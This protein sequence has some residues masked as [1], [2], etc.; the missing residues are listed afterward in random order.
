MDNLNQG[1]AGIN[2]SSSLY[3]AEIA[4]HL[5]VT[6]DE[7]KQRFASRMLTSS[8]PLCQH[9]ESFVINAVGDHIDT[10]RKLKKEVFL[11][12]R[13]SDTEKARLLQ[14]FS[15][16]YRLVFAH[17]PSDIG[18]HL[19]YRALNEI[20]TYRCYDLLSK[21][22]YNDP[23]Y[24]LLIKE[25]GASVPKLVKY[26]RNHVHACTPNLNIDDTIRITNTLSTLDYYQRNGDK[27]QRHLAKLYMRDPKYRCYNKSQYCFTRC[28][29]LIFAHSSYDCTLT[30]IAN[31]MDSSCAVKAIGFIHY[32][33]KIL[34]NLTKGNDNGLNWELT[35]RHKRFY[36]T[37]WFD[38]DYQNSYHHDLDTYL[39]IVKTSLCTS[40]NGNSYIIQRSEEL[41][42]LLFYTILK[43]ARTINKST[44]IRKLPFSDS[45]DIIVHYYNLQSDPSKYNY[46][47]LVPIRLVV[48]KKFFE[49]LYYYLQIL[50]EGKFTVQNALSMAS[51]MASRTIVNG[52]YVSQPYNL[53]IDCI[54]NVAYA[55]YFIVY[56]R[57]YDYLEVLK[58]LKNFEDIK[59]NP[60]FFRKI[61]CILNSLKNFVLSS[62][63]DPYIPEEE[64]EHV[65]ANA[66]KTVVQNESLKHSHN[67]FQWLL[68]LFRINNRYD[69]RFYPVTR[70]VSV[71]EDI[72]VIKSVVTT[73]PIIS[74]NDEMVENFIKEQLK[75]T[76]VQPETCQIL[77]RDCEE[78]LYTVK[79]NYE[80]KCVLKCVANALNLDLSLVI[81][82]LK[83]SKFLEEVSLSLKNSLLKCITGDVADIEL[84]ELV[85]CEFGINVCVH[86]DTKHSLYDVGAALTYHFRV[87]DNHC[88][89]MKVKCICSPFVFDYETCERRNVFDFDI[90]KAC[91]TR[92]R[93]DKYKLYP[94]TCEYKPYV[95]RSVLKLHEI[96][97]HYNVLS[98]GKVCEFSA[99]PGSWM[100]YVRT[101][102]SSARRYYTH[103]DEGLPITIDS[104]AV[105]LN[106]TT[107]GDLTS[108]TDRREIETQI[109]KH[110][111]MDV[112]LC[113]AAIM[114]NDDVADREQFPRFQDYF[115]GNLIN[116]LNDGG[117]VVFKSFCEFDLSDVVNMVLNHFEEVYIVKPTFSSAIS[118]EYYIVAKNLDS[119]KEVVDPIDYAPYVLSAFG[120]VLKYCNMLQKNIFPTQTQYELPRLFSYSEPIKA[121][122]DVSELDAEPELEPDGVIECNT[123]ESKF[124]DIFNKF[125][126]HDNAVSGFEVTQDQRDI[127]PDVEIHC[128][129][130]ALCDANGDYTDY[131]FNPR[132]L[133]IHLDLSAVDKLRV[134]SMFSHVANK[135]QC[136]RLKVYID[137]SHISDSSSA[138]EILSYIKQAFERHYV[139]VVSSYLDCSYSISEYKRAIVEYTD[140]IHTYRGKCSNEYR[141]YY[142]MFKNASYT[143]SVSLISNLLK[144]TEQISIYYGTDMVFKNPNREPDDYSHCYDGTNFIR[145]SEMVAGKYYF[146]G[147]YTHKMF[148]DHI[149]E[150]MSQVNVA[151]LENVQFVLVQGV[152]GHGKT[153]EIVESHSPSLKCKNGGDLILTPTTAG[154]QVLVERT[155]LRKGID[156]NNLDMLKYRTINSFLINRNTTAAKVYIDEVMMVHV[157]L[158][159]TAAH[160]AGAKIVYLYGDTLQ[161]PAHSQLGDFEM[162]YNSPLSLFKVTEVRHKSYRIP[163]DVAA[164]LNSEYTAAHQK[165]GFNKGLV[166][167]NTQLRSLNAI[168]INADSA[169][170][171]YFN[172]DCK[173][174]SFTHTAAS[175]LRK[176][177]PL[178]N[179]STIAAFQGSENRDIAVVRFSPS[180]SDPIY[181]NIHICITAITRHTR[182]FT[183]YTTCEN[184]ILYN[185]I[186]KSKSLSDLAVREFGT[187]VNIG[188]VLPLIYPT[189]EPV[190]S[191][192]FFVSRKNFTHEYTYVDYRRY[193][194]EKEFVVAT[195]SITR[196]LFV[197]KSI[198]KK[199]NMSELIK[200][201]KK[202]APHVK[203]VY[204]KVHNEPFSDDSIV[205]D[206]VETYKCANTIETKVVER[207][208][209]YKPYIPPDVKLYNCIS[210]KPCL[211]MLQVFMSH[212]YPQS[213]FVNTD[214][215]AY[216]VHTQDIEYFLS[217]VSFCPLWDRYVA[218]EHG[219]DCLRPKLSTP[220]PALRDVTQREILLGIQKR[221]L[222][223]PELIT[224]SSPDNTS[225]HLLQNFCSKFFVR[226][227]DSV[228]KDM[229]PIYPTTRSIVSWL[230]RQDRSV[231]KSLINE[232]PFFLD[233]LSECSLSLKRNPKVRITPDSIDVYD[234]VQTI[235]FH[236]KHINAFFC[237]VIEA[238]QDR[239]MKLM[240]PWVIFNTKITAE[241]LGTKC[242][243]IWSTYGKVY[244]FSG[245]DSLLINGNRFKEMDMSK[246]DKSQ[247]LFALEF[248]CAL[249]KRFGVPTHIAQLYF[250]MMYY[251][252]CKD[253][254]NKV[255][256]RLTPQ[257]ESGSAATY[258]GN[259][260]FCAAVI[261]SCLDLED[262]SYTPRFEKFSQ[263][264]N[265][266][267]KEFNYVN[268]YFCSKFVV[269]TE[270]T[271]RFYPD[272]VKILIKLGRKD[273]KN[274]DHL[275]E[276]FTSMRDLVSQYDTLTDIQSISAAI[277]ERYSFPYDCTH[278]I[279]NL[280]SVLNDFSSFKSLYFT[281]PHDV[282]DLNSNKFSEM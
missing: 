269:I 217:N 83:D 274:F 237:S 254:V 43:P 201:Y 128:H 154:K 9:Y 231:L 6:P 47:E 183:Y 251:R 71:E 56:C 151:N 141:Y 35:M 263:M 165:F 136:L 4:K 95:C 5:D 236:K 187:S 242:Y 74:N 166:T 211:D 67:V 174:L 50:P 76:R 137:I 209:E 3:A 11:N 1:F 230:E 33:P 34:S 26:K 69:V 115:F 138:K 29:F 163:M 87:V 17:D 225:D 132:N 147:K 78:K 46:H 191:N 97:S 57:R 65:I 84:F 215:D 21:D 100:Q 189:T 206:M 13:L 119:K 195:K 169:M 161:I 250:E 114:S 156:R 103:Y 98:H 22:V 140:Y 8:N 207:L 160:H 267:T 203:K 133:S 68:K 90:L 227:F 139:V 222:N 51:T 178:F 245:D 104:D 32:S 64:L 110:E 118:T 23:Q 28:K 25:V 204:V 186:K 12:Q 246:F 126:F 105:L 134:L 31:M 96:D 175:E 66:K 223:P 24:D 63:F 244:L 214:Y 197:D 252:V 202:L 55:A 276:F 198:F 180:P 210:V 272:P 258:L 19:Y 77:E 130:G 281:C 79:N 239:I 278:H 257:M 89:E 135:L 179:P 170:K 162:A 7:V 212:L 241:D 275:H 260:C 116:F 173:Y 123:F 181:N 193:V 54:D 158:I 199:F 185:L 238:V 220:C 176:V 91:S 219:F 44:I 146:V 149:L 171:D 229:E 262:Y 124:I 184:D 111:Y 38:N 261:A 72:A 59:R 216:F 268:P 273:L 192:K 60:T 259:T 42:G 80:T 144:F 167:A 249:L 70:V 36:I 88:M 15:P 279:L 200:W 93:A 86:L 248:I 265:L 145:L 61:C 270:R 75:I 131:I 39:G 58:T 10:V 280:V 253:P 117:N 255:T 92:S 157:A 194:S 148:D 205:V 52:A 188:S 99:A 102:Y 150:A 113:D 233:S 240:F 107:S 271:F 27:E 190:S 37:F 221:N 266:E 226:H 45:D 234:S 101:M 247:L 127:N 73:L 256:M 20:A 41:G 18:A 172:A 277:C 120:R 177:N 94:V 122:V 121:K 40:S 125:T 232:V 53:S 228:I 208:E 224:L 182:S 153:R 82:S 106:P 143:L 108:H 196:D 85:A 81:K 155:V 213:V 168:K 159:L 218:K 49:R 62:N 129:D 264:F 109:E 235:T 142:N 112:M 14:L 164:V 2:P 282:L 30:D 48:P 152:A 243:D 16:P